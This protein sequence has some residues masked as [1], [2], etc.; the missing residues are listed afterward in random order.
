MTTTPTTCERFDTAADELALGIMDE[1]Q[2]SQL[3]L[4]A[5]G[6]ARCS[7]LLDGLGGVGDRVL[8]L[9][10][11]LEPPAGFESRALQ[12][13]GAEAAPAG[14][15]SRAP[16]RSWATVAA[17]AI[18]LALAGAGVAVWAQRA[19]GAD[20]LAR[21][22]IVAANGSTV[23]TVE[24]SASP[25]PHVLIAVT[26]PRAAPGVRTCELLGAD[27]RWV[28]VGNWTVEEIQSGVW[29]AGIDASLLDA[30]AMRVVTEDGSVL[31]TA[32]LRT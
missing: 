10:P 22:P 32:D 26:A 16:R 17:V 13:M 1:P 12:R 21:A 31:A 30:R 9:A 19:V 11:Q 25:T 29:A 4:H 15:A 5:T 2:R 27:G 6:C 7:A 8:G 18:V 20:Q 14:G 28:A 3:L 24:L 23:G